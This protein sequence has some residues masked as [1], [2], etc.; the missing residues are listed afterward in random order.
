MGA[1][2]A[3]ESSQYFGGGKVVEGV[4]SLRTWSALLLRTR[5]GISIRVC[6]SRSDAAFQAVLNMIL[7]SGLNHR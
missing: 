3:V 5:A 6:T 7:L 2:G 4:R 1:A